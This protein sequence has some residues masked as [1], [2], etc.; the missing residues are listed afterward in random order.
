MKSYQAHEF[1]YRKMKDQGVGAWSKSGADGDVVAGATERFFED[2]LAQGWMPKKGRVIELG[3]GT[4]AISRWFSQ[5]GYSVVG[6]DISETAIERAEENS[7]DL[8][9]EF[10]S[11]DVTNSK[12]CELGNFDIVIDGH[13]LHCLT[14][15]KA[16]TNFISNAY[17]MLRKGGVF[18]AETMCAPLNR[19]AV[20]VVWEGQQVVGHVMYAPCE[21]QC[22]YE[23]AMEIE[24]VR[25]LPTRY[26]T[27]WKRI[28]G[29]IKRPGFTVQQ[30]RQVRY[31]RQVP[32][33]DFA[34]AAIKP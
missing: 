3:C 32:V 10:H 17:A 12:I 29:E 8:G 16:R 6:V 11:K 30:F 9:I 23:D 2:L 27:H 22:G 1:E 31:T 28:L 26:V 18:V 4:G 24:G 21:G 19:K 34:L 25:F 7:K 14:D 15:K 13:C 33:S 20:P 5:K